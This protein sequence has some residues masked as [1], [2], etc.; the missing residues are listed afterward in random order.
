MSEIVINSDDKLSKQ[1]LEIVELRKKYPCYTLQQIGDMNGITRERV[2]QILKNNHLLTYSSKCA[3]CGE[4]KHKTTTRYC[5]KCRK[6]LNTIQV[7]CSYCHKLF[8]RDKALLIYKTKINKYNGMFCCGNHK[9]LYFQN[10][11]I[12]SVW[13]RK[14]DYA[15][16]IGLYNSGLSY[17]EIASSLKANI[18]SIRTF[19]ARYKHNQIKL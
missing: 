15:E 2:R 9:I 16:I 14:Y 4:P 6:I 8:P 19:I 12:P 18:G 11:H 7:E 17:K 3:M 5:V 13:L 10:N 1:S